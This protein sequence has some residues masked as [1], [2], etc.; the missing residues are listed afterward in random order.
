MIWIPYGT[1]FHTAEHLTELK[2]LHISWLLYYLFDEYIL[3][4]DQELYLAIKSFQ[5]RTL[6]K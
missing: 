3:Y 4:H 1:I 2:D 5:Q 6:H